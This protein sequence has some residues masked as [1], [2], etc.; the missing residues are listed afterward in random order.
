MYY[1]LNPTNILE[2]PDVGDIPKAALRRAMKQHMLL[3]GH[4][5]RDLS[6]ADVKSLVEMVE[7]VRDEEER[8]EIGQASMDLIMLTMILATAE[9]CAPQN[10]D[11]VVEYSQ[12]LSTIVIYESLA[13]KGLARMFYDKVSFV[14][15]HAIIVEHI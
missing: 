2:S 13:R 4:W 3:P 5:L 10:D 6:T 8:G 11:E 1:S 15:P 14:E 12:I 7:L 9:G